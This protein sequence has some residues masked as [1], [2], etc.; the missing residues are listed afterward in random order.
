MAY[1]QKPKCYNNHSFAAKYPNVISEHETDK[2]R[3]NVQR[4]SPCRVADL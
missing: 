2:S 4:S 1:G 3:V